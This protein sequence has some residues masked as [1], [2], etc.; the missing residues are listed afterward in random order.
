MKDLQ[1]VVGIV[2]KL[3]I[4]YSTHWETYLVLYIFMHYLFCSAV[5]EPRDLCRLEMLYHRT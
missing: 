2:K 3:P 4:F 5:I 1:C